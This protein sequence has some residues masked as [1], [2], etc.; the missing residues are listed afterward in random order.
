MGHVGGRRWFGDRTK[1]LF[2]A[3]HEWHV[4]HDDPGHDL[5]AR[6]HLFMVVAEHG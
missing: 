2:A 6:L 1:G 4:E 5:A 3:V